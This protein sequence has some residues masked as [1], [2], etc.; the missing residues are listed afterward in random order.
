[1]SSRDRGFSLH[2]SFI[3]VSRKSGFFAFFLFHV[4]FGWRRCHIVPW[5]IRL[6]LTEAK[7]SSLA[8]LWL[9]IMTLTRVSEKIEEGRMIANESN[10]ERMR[11]WCEAEASS[12]VEF[13]ESSMIKASLIASKL[14]ACRLLRFR[15]P[16]HEWA[17]LELSLIWDIVS[18]VMQTTFPL[19][20]RKCD[21]LRESESQLPN[22]SKIF[23]LIRNE[24]MC[25]CC[26]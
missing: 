17:P 23:T 8:E 19:C 21:M 11:N 25:Y 18:K 12:Y 10:V 2:L 20:L 16:A 15:V 5:L 22:I 3:F 4:L 24:F 26:A 13:Q 9:S 1:M 7:T 14:F 6:T